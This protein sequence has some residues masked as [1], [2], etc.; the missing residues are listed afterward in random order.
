MI[1][2]R[3]RKNNI[4]PQLLSAAMMMGGSTLTMGLAALAAMAGKALMLSMLSLVLSALS[5]MGNG[6]SNGHSQKQTTYEII[7]KPV[8]TLNVLCSCVKVFGMNI[9]QSFGLYRFNTVNIN[10]VYLLR[11]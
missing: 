3:R 1:A 4:W 9:K 6:G 8:R 5:G 2:A 11:C 10:F 7:S